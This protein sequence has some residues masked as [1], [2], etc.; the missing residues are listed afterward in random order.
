M[1]AQSLDDI[2]ELKSSVKTALVDLKNPESSLWSPI[3]NFLRRMDDTFFV[4]EDVEA[5]K[6]VIPP[7]VANDK[8]VNYLHDEI[9]KMIDSIDEDTPVE[10]AGFA[11]STLTHEYSHAIRS[12]REGVLHTVSQCLQLSVRIAVPYGNFLE[13]N[14]RESQSEPE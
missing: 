12:V 8:G 11:L 6:K 2:R 1:E 10:I 7:I 5:L 13:E 3:L 14:Q 9:C 4:E